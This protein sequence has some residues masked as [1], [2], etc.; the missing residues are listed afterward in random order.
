MIAENHD[1]RL[2]G[3]PFSATNTSRVRRIALG[4]DWDST[5]NPQPSRALGNNFIQKIGR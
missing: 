4:E 1:S 5:L 2:G 3:H